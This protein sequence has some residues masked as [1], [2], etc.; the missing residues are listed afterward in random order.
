MHN[1]EKYKSEENIYRKAEIMDKPII[2]DLLRRNLFKNL[3]EE[4]REKEGFIIYEP[5]DEEFVKIVKDTGIY[6]SFRGNEFKEYF[7]TM[8]KGLARTIPLQAEFIANADKMS[9]E[10]KPL[11]EYNYALIAQIVVAKEFRGGMTFNKLHIGT[12]SMLKEQGYEL[13]VGEVADINKKSLAVHGYLT[14]IGIYT[15]KSGFK[16]HV[17]VAD[18]RKD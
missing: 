12:Q 11:A 6:L 2:L 9:Y 10:G 15:A 8:S 13:G 5:T 7:I 4:E 1:P 14:D 3:S 17:V 18:L 16:W